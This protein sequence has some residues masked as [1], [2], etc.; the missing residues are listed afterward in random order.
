MC[1]CCYYCCMNLK[2]ERRREEEGGEMKMNIN[3]NEG[4]GGEEEEDED[5]YT[6]DGSVDIRG[7]PASKNKTGGWIAASL[8]LGTSSLSF[9]SFSIYLFIVYF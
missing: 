1:C 4:F 5:E 6:M 7:N 3:I 8:V 9:F 2:M